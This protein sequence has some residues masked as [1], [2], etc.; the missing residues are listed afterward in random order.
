MN[1]QGIWLLW[2]G[3]ET[4]IERRKSAWLEVGQSGTRV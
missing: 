1:T 3:R 2:S 4:N